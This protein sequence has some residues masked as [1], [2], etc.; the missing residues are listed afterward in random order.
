MGSTVSL[1][2]RRNQ[3]LLRVKAHPRSIRV[4]HTA[5]VCFVLC[6]DLKSSLLHVLFVYVVAYCPR[7]GRVEQAPTRWQWRRQLTSFVLH[8]PSGPPPLPTW[9]GHPLNVPR[10]FPHVPAACSLLRSRDVQLCSSYVTLICN[11][12][13]TC[14]RCPLCWCHSR[15]LR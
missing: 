10:A 15:S 11:L 9:L 4:Q 5:S 12:V 6:P 8:K 1:K 14:L 7:A 2:E 3:G 13:S